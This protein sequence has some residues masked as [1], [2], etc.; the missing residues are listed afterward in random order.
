MSSRRKRLNREL[1]NAVVMRDTV[2]VRE[3]LSLGADVGARDAEHNETPLI[4]AAKFADAAMVQLLLDAGA[5]VNARDDGGRTPLF[6]AQVSS[7]VF[8]ILLAA[9]ADP[10]TRDNE[11]NTILMKTVSGSPSLSEVDELLQ[12]G[13]DASHQNENGKAA[14]DLADQLGLVMIVERLTKFGG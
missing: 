11:G 8:K 12:L 9:G 6:F 3:L 5:E 1:L 14:V 2:K 7:E 13:I 10:H 4:L